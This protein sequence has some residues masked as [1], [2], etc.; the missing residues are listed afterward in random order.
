MRRAHGFTLLEVLIALAI[1]A[2]IGV[3]SYRV[4]SSVMET[5]KRIAIRAE[6][7]RNVNRAFWMLQ[8]DVEQLVPRNVRDASGAFSS[9]DNYLLVKNDD[10]IPLQFTRGGR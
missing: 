4:L 2:L 9:D 3:A 10:A 8:Q 7:M 6:Q 5:N 1:F